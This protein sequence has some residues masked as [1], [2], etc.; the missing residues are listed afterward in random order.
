M[1]TS[2]LANKI[3]PLKLSAG[4]VIWRSK[5]VQGKHQGNPAWHKYIVIIV[6]SLSIIDQRSG[7]LNSPRCLPPFPL[8]PVLQ[9]KNLKHVLSIDFSLSRCAELS[10]V[11]SE[12]VTIRNALR[13]QATAAW[14][15]N[16]P[17]RP[18][19][20]CRRPLHLCSP[21]KSQSYLRDSEGLIGPARCHS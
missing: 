6:L 12:P 18:P 2:R 4:V 1:G 15:S 10:C 3:G 19:G 20:C 16:P 17:R 13:G 9:I 7:T 8:E 11:S 14:Y 5:K 21:R